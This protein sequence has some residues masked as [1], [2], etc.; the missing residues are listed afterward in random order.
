[1]SFYKI[2]KAQAELIGKFDFGKNQKFDPFVGE[3]KDGS[4]LVSEKMYTMLK[5]HGA[6]K[7]VDFKTRPTVLKQQLDFEIKVIPEEKLSAAER[8]FDKNNQQEFVEKE[9]KKQNEINEQKIV[10]FTRKMSFLKYFF[11]SFERV[12]ATLFFGVFLGTIGVYLLPDVWGVGI[13]SVVIVG[14]IAHFIYEY[15]YYKKVILKEKK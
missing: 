12:F 13:L 6:L 7:K 9:F 1:M 15:Y 10:K 11:S 3:Q 8:I 14:E 4:F 2:T 5:E